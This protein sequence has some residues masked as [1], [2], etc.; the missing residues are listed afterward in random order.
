MKFPVLQSMESF[1]QSDVLGCRIKYDS[2]EEVV[3]FS[4]I[5]ENF[6]LEI[7]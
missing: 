1:G 2:N 3:L 6:S 7:F 4:V 5:M